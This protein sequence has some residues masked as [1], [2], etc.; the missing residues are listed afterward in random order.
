VHYPI[1]DHRQ[2]FPTAKPSGFSLPATELAAAQVVSVPMFPDL[3]ESEVD[4]VSA[5][6]AEYGASH[7]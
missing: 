4:R 3:T 1:P 5:A 7:G 2:D 6:L